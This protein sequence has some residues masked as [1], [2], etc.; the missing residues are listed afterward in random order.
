VQEPLSSAYL[1]I[2]Q[3]S[4]PGR[5]VE[6]YK[7][8]TTLGRSRDCDIFLEDVAVHRKQ[9]SIVFTRAGYVLRDDH[10]S[11]DSLVNGRPVREHLLSDGDHHLF[12]TTQLIWLCCNN[13]WQ[14]ATSKE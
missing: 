10:G 4:Q 12:G 7:D 11:G 3:G 1:V 9:A 5:R 8:H 2:Q 6:I 13:L 14:N